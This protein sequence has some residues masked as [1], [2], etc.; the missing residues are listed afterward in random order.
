MIVKLIGKVSYHGKDFIFFDVESVSYKIAVP[1]FAIA[2]FHGDMTLYT[3]EV[4][5]DDVH[6]LFG[7]LNMDELELFWKLIS[8]SGVGPRSAQK[9]VLAGTEG[10]ARKKIM[11]GD[12]AFL[13]SVPGIGK[14]TAQKIVLELKGVLAEDSAMAG[15]DAD[16]VSALVGLGYSRR[17]AERALEGIDGTTE[18]K[19]KVALKMM[20]K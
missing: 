12:L 19:I 3:H 9:I 11:A 16:A 10:E 13:Q 17:E 1:E 2:K 5:R 20:A 6:E 8:I 14:K 15:I 7:F 18:E 4:Q